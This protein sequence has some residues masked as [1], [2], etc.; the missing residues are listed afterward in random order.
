METPKVEE[1]STFDVRR[2]MFDVGRRTLRR[3]KE[4]PQ[5]AVRGKMDTGRRTRGTQGLEWL[6]RKTVPIIQVD[7]ARAG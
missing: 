5:D 3:G 4:N 2:W 1:G 7:W 6:R